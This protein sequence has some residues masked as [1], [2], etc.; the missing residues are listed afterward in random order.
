MDE[1]NPIFGVKQ[2]GRREQSN[3]S[4]ENKTL[5]TETIHLRKAA[6]EESEYSSLNN[7]VVAFYVEGLYQHIL[8]QKLWSFFIIKWSDTIF[9]FLNFGNT[10]QWQQSLNQQ[11]LVSTFNIALGFVQL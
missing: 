5:L 9:Q 11:S 2:T 3:F 7:M 4:R 10:K 8:F 6:S 1:L